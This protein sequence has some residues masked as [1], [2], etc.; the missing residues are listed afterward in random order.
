MHYNFKEIEKK[1]QKKWLDSHAFAAQADTGRK[2]VKTAR[3]AAEKI[4]DAKRDEVQQK[5]SEFDLEDIANFE[6]DVKEKFNIDGKV[7]I[8]SGTIYS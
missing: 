7:K 4:F 1:W 6:K 8:Y 3:L 5:K 2:N